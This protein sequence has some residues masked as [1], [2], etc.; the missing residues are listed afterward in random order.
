MF[1]LSFFLS[2]ALLSAQAATPQATTPPAPLAQ[3]VSPALVIG[4]VGGFVRHDDQVHGPVQLAATMHREFPTGVY[5][6]V[7]ENRRGERAHAE[8]IRRLDTDHDRT[9]SSEEKQSARIILYGDSWGGSEAITL[10]RELRKDGVPVLL[11]IQVDGV[12]RVGQNDVLIP[13]NVA[14]AVNF[15]QTTGLL[16]GTTQIRAVD[17]TRTRILG[18]YRFDYS[19][20]PLRC[21]QYPWYD[22]FFVKAHTEIE[23][24]PSV[25]SRAES[26]IRSKLQPDADK[27]AG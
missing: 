19:A 8:I 2:I 13:D 27:S 23:C 22:R 6:E 1:F 3:E 5:V 10:A 12:P 25:W 9:L 26:L 21:D 4:F 11:L 15:Y 17:S 24:D 18:N 16:H 20:H 7:F 14:E